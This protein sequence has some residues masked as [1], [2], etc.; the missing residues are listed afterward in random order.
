[1]VMY[2]NKG[3]GLEQTSQTNWWQD[4]V[5]LGAQT[6]ANIANAQWA[7]VPVYSQSN[8]PYGSVTQVYQPGVSPQPGTQ[9]VGA[10]GAVGMGSGTILLIGGALLLVVMM[11][12]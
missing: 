1:M 10:G 6:G 7:T 9:I 11:N 5:T 4:L 12:K 8:T 2:Q 3:L